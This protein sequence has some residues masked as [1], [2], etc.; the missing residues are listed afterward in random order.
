MG[1]LDRALV[2]AALLLHHLMDR[3]HIE[4]F[5]G[6]ND[7]RTFGNVVDVFMPG[8]TARGAEAPIPASRAAPD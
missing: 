3:Q 4:I 8:D 6:E 2:P 7:R 5:V 1:D